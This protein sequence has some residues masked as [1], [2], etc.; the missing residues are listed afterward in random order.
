M[1]LTQAPIP[2]PNLNPIHTPRPPT[3][4]MRQTIP[5][6]PISSSRLRAP[7]LTAHVGP[8]VRRQRQVK[9]KPAEHHHRLREDDGR[10]ELLAPRS[11]AVVVRT[12]VAEGR[13]LVLAAAVDAG[14]VYAESASFDD[15]GVAACSAAAGCQVWRMEKSVWF[16]FEK[17]R[18]NSPG[19]GVGARRGH[20]EA[21]PEDRIIPNPPFPLTITPST[22]MPHTPIPQP[23]PLPAPLPVTPMPLTI[24]SRRAPRVLHMRRLDPSTAP[25]LTGMRHARTLGARHPSVVT[26]RLLLEAAV[27]LAA[28]GRRDA[29]LVDVGEAP[30]P[31]G[32]AHA[33]ALAVAGGIVGVACG[34]GATG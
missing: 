11:R 6:T 24:P 17:T 2:S 21:L 27:V 16:G 4:R 32:G 29:V 20:F 33:V 1:L 7:F 9:V 22:R 34:A 13:T 12:E 3:P 14:V 18:R 15:A 31:G 28:V 30:A 26:R 23:P 10:A 8:A 25:V 19:G 5:R